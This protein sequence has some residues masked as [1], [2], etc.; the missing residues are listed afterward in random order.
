MQIGDLV[1]VLA[2]FTE[3]FPDTYAITEVI[4]YEGGTVTYVLGES[5][6]FDPVYLE[7]AQ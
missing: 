6:G 1:R 3:S 2:P 4:T 7:F 5:G